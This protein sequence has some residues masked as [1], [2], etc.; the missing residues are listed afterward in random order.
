MKSAI[1]AE[2]NHGWGKII[3]LHRQRIAECKNMSE[4]VERLVLPKN[5]NCS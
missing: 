5:S 3:A 1:L 2:G 4:I